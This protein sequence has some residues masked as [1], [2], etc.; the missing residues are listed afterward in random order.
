MKKHVY[1]INREY[2]TVHDDSKN[3]MDQHNSCSSRNLAGARQFLNATEA[4][5]GAMLYL[6]SDNV[7]ESERETVVNEITIFIVEVEEVAPSITVQGVA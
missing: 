3:Y 2:S 1:V 4:A 7:F 5:R 6:L